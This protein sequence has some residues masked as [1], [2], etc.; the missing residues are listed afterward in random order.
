MAKLSES[1][2]ISLGRAC[3]L[4]GANESTLRQ[5][6]DAGRLRT[7]RT[8]GG[9]RRFSREDIAALVDSAE[10][11]QTGSMSLPE[12]ALALMRQRL[13]RRGGPA[14]PWQDHFDDDGKSR[15]RILGRRLVALA[16]DYLDQRRPKRE[17][18]EE[19]R[20]L[21]IEYGRELAQASVGLPQAVSAFIFFRDALHEAIGSRA[22][23]RD[24]LAL[25]E[26]VRP[27]E[28][29]ILLAISE[30]YERAWAQPAAPGKAAVR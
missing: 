4:L 9:H 7:F 11:A 23:G 15:M 24:I 25:R 6:A 14:R 8:P 12:A 1:N 28:D 16:T 13:S 26:D 10:P 3:E 29:E 19:A 27:L 30:V 21:G 2:W 17:L 5:W 18:T 20:Y 22:K